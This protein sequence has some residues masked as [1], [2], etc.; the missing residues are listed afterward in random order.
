M[1]ETVLIWLLV[2]Q[3]G[4]FLLCRQKQDR[5]PFAGQWVLPGA[6]MEA[7]ESASETISRFAA[8]EL[9]IKVSEEEFVDTFF[10]TEPGVKYAINVFRPGSVDGPM[11]YREGG[12]YSETRW[13]RPQEARELGLSPKPLVELLEGKRH[14]QT[15]QALSN[16]APSAGR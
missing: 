1:S 5:K 12:P 7:D 2:E 10:L 9:D 16:D 15:S 13:F 14:W 8:G 4:A 11:R 3:E 6:R